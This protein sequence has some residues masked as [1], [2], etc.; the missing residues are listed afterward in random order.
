[1]YPFRVIMLFFAISIY[2]WHIVLNVFNYSYYVHPYDDNTLVAFWFLFGFGFFDFVSAPATGL[3]NRFDII[4]N[5][6]RKSFYGRN[7][8]FQKSISVSLHFNIGFLSVHLHHWLYLAFT[9][10]ILQF[11]NFNFTFAFCFGG[12]I[13]GLKYNDW[14]IV[15][16]KI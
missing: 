10:F 1:M 12:S 16:S 8:Y 3:P 13:Q 5:S 11:T 9:C 14:Y 15:F 2:N 4:L 6:F 7:F